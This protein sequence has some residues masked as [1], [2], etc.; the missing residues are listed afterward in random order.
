LAGLLLAGG[1]IGPRARSGFARRLSNR[2][3]LDGTTSLD[4][5]DQP[6]QASDLLL[7]PDSNA[8][9]R[10]SSSTTVVVGGSSDGS[11]TGSIFVVA[12]TG[13]NYGGRMSSSV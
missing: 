8:E 13:G 7:E 11:R 10:L 5:S 9:L 12:D 1:G 6:I 4:S 2:V 3:A